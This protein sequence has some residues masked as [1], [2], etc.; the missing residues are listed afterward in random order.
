MDLNAA[1]IVRLQSGRCRM[2]T[3]PA[4][5][6]HLAARTNGSRQ[7]YVRGVTFPGKEAVTD[8]MFDIGVEAQ[9]GMQKRNIVVITAGV[10]VGICTTNIWKVNGWECVGT[11]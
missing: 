3:I 2:F 9:S 4:G 6:S 1:A 5:L 8:E 11:R 7:Q 10:P